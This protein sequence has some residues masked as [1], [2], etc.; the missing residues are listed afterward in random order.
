[1]VKGANN[2]FKELGILRRIAACLPACPAVMQPLQR[3][4][5]MDIGF[6]LLSPINRKT[7]A[8]LWSSQTTA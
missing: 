7:L 8:S 3:G 4:V 2:A 5:R 6:G 1:M